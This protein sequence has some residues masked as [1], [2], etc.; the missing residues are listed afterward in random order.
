PNPE[1]RPKAVF[2]SSFDSKPLAPDFEYVIKGNEVDFQAG[3]S[4][5]FA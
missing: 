3:L 5:L 1:S 4:A 2:V